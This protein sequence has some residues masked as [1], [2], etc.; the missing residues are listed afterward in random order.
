MN[1][2]KATDVFSSPSWPQKMSAARLL[3]AMA[4]P[5]R[6]LLCSCC[7]A[8]TS[9]RQ[10][11]NRDIGYGLCVAC[12]PR[13]SRGETLAQF[14]RLYGVRGIHFDLPVEPCRRVFERSFRIVVQFTGANRMA[15]ANAFMELH[16]EVGLIEDNDTTAYL[17]LLADRGV[18]AQAAGGGA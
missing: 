6:S 17:A 16:E 2:D 5:E 15:E 13:C 3:A 11:H 7:G 8:V 10:W 4:A 12:I 18:I 1:V 9:G 14:E